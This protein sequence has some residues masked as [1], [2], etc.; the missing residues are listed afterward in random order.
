MTSAD[1]VGPFPD[2]TPKP[3]AATA[4][5]SGPMRL[6][7][8]RAYN[9]IFENPNWAM[10]LVWSF[11]CQLVTQIIPIVPAMVFVGY[12]FESVEMLVANGGR[13]YP[14]FDTNRIGEYLSRGVWPVLAM[15]IVYL[16][17]MPFLG[18]G[19]MA[20]I[21]GLAAAAG[22]T[23]DDTL[24]PLIFFGGA[25]LTMLF[26]MLAMAAISVLT[27]PMMLRA[28]LKQ[29]FGAAFEFGWVRGFIGKMWLES[30]LSQVFV[31]MSAFGLM[32]ITCGLA[33]LVLGPL[34]PF[35]QMHFFYQLYSIYLARG[36]TPI[37]T[38][39]MVP[40]VAQ[41][42]YLGTPQY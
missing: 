36:G 32:L 42:P 25:S 2:P 21:F 10:N 14:D 15:F 41:Q 23:Q 7:Y 31:A 1:P 24:G 34:L 33:L 19:M 6:E 20:S 40:P 26:L 16:I 38:K 9:Y 3:F 28:G 11:V 35:V 12:Q 39:P 27:I 29:E 13:R 37:P 8:L 18:I 17:C 30:L 5:P 22:G 4:A